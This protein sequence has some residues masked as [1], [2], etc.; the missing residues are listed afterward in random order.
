MGVAEAAVTAAGDEYAF[1]RLVEVGDQHFIVFVA[2]LGADRHFQHRVGT[3]GAGHVAAPA[4]GAGGCLEMLLVAEVD[5]RVEVFDRLDPYVAALAAVAAVR[6]AELD[7]LL[8]AEVH[9]AIAAVA[10]AHIDLG[11]VE[12]LHLKSA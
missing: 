2:D 12:E 4:G 10:G 3:V 11:L 8:A 7:E 1:S 5:E 9:A 6:S